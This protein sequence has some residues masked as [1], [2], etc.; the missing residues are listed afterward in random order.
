[1]LTGTI[2]K[3]GAATADGE[4]VNDYLWWRGK[5]SLSDYY[6][7]VGFRSDA[8][9][10]TLR[11]GALDRGDPEALQ[12]LI[13]RLCDT[14]SMPPAP[15]P[16]LCAATLL[17]DEL[18]AALSLDLKETERY[19]LIRQAIGATDSDQWIQRAARVSGLSQRRVQVAQSAVSGI[20]SQIVS[21]SKRLDEVRASLV[22]EETLSDALARLRLFTQVDA[23]LEQIAEHARVAISDTRL[24]YEALLTLRSVYDSISKYREQLPVLE[25]SLERAVQQQEEVNAR[26][27]TLQQESNPD[28]AEGLDILANEIAE[29]VTLGRKLGLHDGKCPLC[30]AQRSDDEYAKGLDAGIDRAKQINAQ[31]IRRFQ[32]EVALRQAEEALTIANRAVAECQDA[33]T[34]ARTQLGNFDTQLANSGLPVTAQRQDVEAAAKELEASI[35]FIGEDLRI[36]D[37]IK[38]NTE[39]ERIQS[40]LVRLNQA[41]RRAEEQLGFAKRGETRSQLIHDATRRAAGEALDQRLERVLPL[42]VELYRRLRPHPV[43]NDIEYSVRGDVRRFLKLQVGGNL[44][45]QFMFSSGQRRATGLA[46][47][48]AVNLSLA[49]SH[50]HTLLLDDPVQHVDDFRSVHLAE[51]V[52]HLAASGRQI[53]CTVE[54]AALADLLCRRLPIEAIGQGKRLT[55][56]TDNEGFLGVLSQVD[57]SPPPQGTLI[58]EPQ[59]RAV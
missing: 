58:R 45:P 26:V 10:F 44:N 17:R 3:Y 8:G 36:V 15:L 51:V 39:L 1:V 38:L 12:E 33:L 14:A 9:T 22:Q 19:R 23:P 53:I 21:A 31:A 43:W 27:A 34:N 7:E 13:P 50:W 35:E 29:L 42:M 47:L 25:L 46:F 40:E 37:T 55:L 49:W 18:I 57:I 54:D 24:K 32:H 41:Y 5:G 56:G 59:R 2:T 11:R 4:T 48:L 52:S 6:V 28:S 20:S 16:Q 30:D